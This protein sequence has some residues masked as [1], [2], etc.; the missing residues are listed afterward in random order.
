MISHDLKKIEG[1]ETR[2]SLNFKDFTGQCYILSFALG[3][4]FYNKM[5]WIFPW[6]IASKILSLHEDDLILNMS[7]YKNTGL[8]H[9]I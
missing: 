3:S 7:L 5:E 1:F 9:G 4:Y 6:L 2:T 8:P